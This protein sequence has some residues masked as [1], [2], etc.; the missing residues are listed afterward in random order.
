MPK[1]GQGVLSLRNSDGLIRTFEQGDPR[2]KGT[3][4]KVPITDDKFKVIDLLTR[5]RKVITTVGVMK[6]ICH[7]RYQEFAE[8]V[9]YKPRAKPTRKAKSIT[10]MMAE[11]RKAG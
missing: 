3:W 8:P 6:I 10:Q 2:L 5:Q 11:M 1:L 7:V 9:K 4:K